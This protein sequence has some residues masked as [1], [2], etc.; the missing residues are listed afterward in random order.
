MDP[1]KLMKVLGRT[2]KPVLLTAEI[3]GYK[4]KLWGSLP[5][6]LDGPTGPAVKG[7]AYEVQSPEEDALLAAY[8][9]NHYATQL[10]CI[11]FEGGKELIGK[12]FG[13]CGDES[14]LE[15]DVPSKQLKGLKV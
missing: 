10:C 12:T 8:D 7:V 11:D 1:A 9:T 2:D 14:E 3:I 13:W 5:A 6:L 15:E 4:T